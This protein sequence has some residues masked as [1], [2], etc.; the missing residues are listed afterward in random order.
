MSRRNPCIFLTTKHNSGLL[1]VIGPDPSTLVFQTNQDNYDEQV[2]GWNSSEN[3]PF[4]TERIWHVLAVSLVLGFTLRAGR[5]VSWTSWVLTCANSCTAVLKVP[6]SFIFYFFEGQ[7]FL[8]F[9]RRPGPRSPLFDLITQ[10]SFSPW[11]VLAQLSCTNLRLQ[12]QAWKSGAS[13]KR[14]LPEPLTHTV[15]V[16]G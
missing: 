5:G 8:H 10:S 16:S 9:H 13:S 11:H 6:S 4:L 1:L 15:A 14:P 12:R 3:K 2:L 7:E